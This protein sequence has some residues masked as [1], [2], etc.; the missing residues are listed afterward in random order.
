MFSASV[1]AQP[2]ALVPE[3]QPG[4]ILEQQRRRIAVADIEG[5]RRADRD[6]LRKVGVEVGLASEQ[7]HHRVH[8]LAQLVPALDLRDQRVAGPDLPESS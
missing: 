8:L 1:D 3:P 4:E 2:L 7:P 5:L 6:P